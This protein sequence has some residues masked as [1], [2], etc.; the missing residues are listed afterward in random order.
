MTN[1]K[2]QKKSK[3]YECLECNY[4][5][6]RKTHWER[7]I[8]TRKHKRLTN[9]NLDTSHK[10]ECIC[11]KVYKHHSSLIGHKKKNKCEKNESVTK[12]DTFGYKMDTSG[13]MSKNEKFYKCDCGKVYKYS[14]GLSKHKLKCNHM[15]QAMVEFKEDHIASLTSLVKQL[16]EEN[17]ELA[18]KPTTNIT[19]NNNN[20][21]QFNVMNYLNTECA[22]AM[23][24]SDFIKNF[25]FS[26]NDLEILGTKGYQESM[27]Q[28]FVKQ[29]FDMDK[30]KRPIHCSDKKRKSFY[31][32]DNDVWEKD[33]NNEKIIRSVKDFSKVHN[34]TL[35]KWQ[36]NNNDWLDNDRKHDFYLKSIIEFSKCDRDKER[37]KIFNKLTELSLR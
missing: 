25:E 29:L 17:K 23:N 16:I 2:V 6:S 21:T 18:N 24:M 27:E 12:M 32:K 14:Q 26:L 28:T 9:P 5:T 15:N 13:Y 3:K 31:I 34:K 36:G 37:N 30:T 8:E 4:L 35:I 7:H 20:N 1:K 19:N 11:G 10:Y 33:T 22:D